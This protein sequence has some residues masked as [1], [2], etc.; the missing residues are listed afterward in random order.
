MYNNR[1][2][3]LLELMITIAII[4]I[5]AIGAGTGMGGFRQSKTVQNTAKELRDHLADIRNHATSKDRTARMTIALAGGVYTMTSEY[6]TGATAACNAPAPEVWIPIETKD[7]EV[8]NNYNM[9]TDTICFFRDG[10]SSGEVFTVAP[11]A[12]VT[13]RTYTLTTTIATGFIDVTEED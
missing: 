10:S 1:G 9:T 4:G 3:T 7:I 6:S 2:F 11:N 5:V 8:H 13:G 12:G